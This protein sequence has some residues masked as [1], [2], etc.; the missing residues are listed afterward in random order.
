MTN[1]IEWSGESEFYVNMTC[2]GINK[3]FSRNFNA[4]VLNT[5]IRKL[6]QGKKSSAHVFQ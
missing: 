6:D 3:L 5:Q 4:S 1:Q 2:H